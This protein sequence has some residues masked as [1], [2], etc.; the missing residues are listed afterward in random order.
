MLENASIS[1]ERMLKYQL[2]AEKTRYSVCSENIKEICKSFSNEETSAIFVQMEQEHIDILKKMSIE[3]QAK[4]R[5][6]MNEASEALSNPIKI[7]VNRWISLEKCHR[8]YRSKLLNL[9]SEVEL[10]CDK[11]TSYINE[12]LNAF[13]DTIKAKACENQ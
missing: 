2:D 13:E 8:I 7:E 1:F 9:E 11:F 12:D 5:S 3:E 6:K 4:L 10:H